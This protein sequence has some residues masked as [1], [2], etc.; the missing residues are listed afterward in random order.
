MKAAEASIQPQHADTTEQG[1]YGC[2]ALKSVNGTNNTPTNFTIETVLNGTGRN[3]NSSF[4]FNL[5]VITYYHE[6]R[7]ILS[8]I[9]T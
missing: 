3:F 2:D 6:I 9:N 5:N 7:W 4:T 8:H 1:A